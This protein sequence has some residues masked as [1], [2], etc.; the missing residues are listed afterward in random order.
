MFKLCSY[1]D[2]TRVIHVKDIHWEPYYKFNDMAFENIK[3]T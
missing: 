2:G 1:L 3:S